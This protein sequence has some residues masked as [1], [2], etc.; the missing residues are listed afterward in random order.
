MGLV[1]VVSALVAYGAGYLASVVDDLAGKA[2]L[3]VSAGL[4]I[5]VAWVVSWMVIEAT[6]LDWRQPA[7]RAFACDLLAR[8]TLVVDAEGEEATS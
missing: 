4:A 2:V 6:T 3:V 7:R 8:S 1:P 5:T